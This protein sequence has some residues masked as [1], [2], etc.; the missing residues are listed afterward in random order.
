MDVGAL[1]LLRVRLGQEHRARAEVIAADLRRG[2]RLGVAH[3]GVAD[4]GQV[5]A[6][7][8]E[9]RQAARRSGRSRGRPPPATT[10]SSAT[11]IGVLPADAVHHLDGDEAQLLAARRGLARATCRAGT[12]ASRNGSAT[13]TPM[14]F[15]TVRRDRCFLVMNIRC[16]STA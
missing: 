15:R 1:R 9:R 12:I 14:P 11:P 7:R 13:V 4:D 2:E 16:S 6:E 3:V 8:L 10:G 5:V